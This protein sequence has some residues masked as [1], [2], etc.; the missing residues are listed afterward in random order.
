MPLKFWKRDK[1][2]KEKGKAEE[3][4]KPAEPAAPAA[5][6]TKAPAETQPAPVL[7]TVPAAAGAAPPSPAHEPPADAMGATLAE[8]H[9]GLVD[10]G[11]TIPATKAVFEK[12]VAASAG[13]IPA[14]VDTYKAAPYRA[15]TRLL[16]DWLG[17]RAPSDFDP[18]PFLK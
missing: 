16:A 2:E 13:G 9:A 8:A 17:F 3:G 7:E 14:F 18:E 1:G 4:P 11:L 5:A 15:T 10:L 6:E 12:R